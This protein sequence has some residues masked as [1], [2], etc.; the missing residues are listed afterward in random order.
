MCCSPVHSIQSYSDVHKVR[1]CWVNTEKS[2]CESKCF[3]Q[4]NPPMAEEIHLLWMKSLRDEIC[5]A[6]EDKGGF[7][8]I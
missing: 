2:T 8:F 6:A 4:L 3:F 1:N 5:L 7:N